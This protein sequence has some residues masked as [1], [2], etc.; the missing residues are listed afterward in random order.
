[1]QTNPHGEA[2][3]KTVD[4][5]H[6]EARRNGPQGHPRTI[7]S[8]PTIVYRGRRTTAK[9]VFWH[10]RRQVNRIRQT[11]TGK[12]IRYQTNGTPPKRRRS[13]GS[14]YACVRSPTQSRAVSIHTINVA[15]ISDHRPADPTLRA[16]GGLGARDRLRTPRA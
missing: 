15:S 11:V 6:A 3:A 5:R 16:S 10:S 7:T 8:R 4:L 12:P 14:Q 1:M 2:A 13:L 9:S